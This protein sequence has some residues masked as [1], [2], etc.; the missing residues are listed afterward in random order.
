MP[1]AT[2]KVNYT[3]ELIALIVELYDGGNGVSIKEIAA[4]PRVNKPEKSVRGKLV[5]MG[6]YVKPAVEAKEFV[7]EGPSKKDHL[8]TLKEFGFSEDALKGLNNATK[9]ALAEV[10][11]KLNARAA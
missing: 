7:N 11:D 1:E 2:A 10:I 5:H 8:A 4:D 9:P 6:K 3:P